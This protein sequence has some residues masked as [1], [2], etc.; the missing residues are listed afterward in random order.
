M[1]VTLTINCDKCF[2]RLTTD[3]HD[4]T[5]A[6]NYGRDRGWSR[7]GVPLMEDRCPTCSDRYF[8]RTAD[9]DSSN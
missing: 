2:T 5:S 1:S 7:A 8:G 4:A 6:R 3:C 9:S